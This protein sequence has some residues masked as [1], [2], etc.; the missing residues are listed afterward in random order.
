MILPSYWL[1]DVLLA[2]LKDIVIELLLEDALLKAL[3]KYISQ[4][5]SRKIEIL[6][7]WSRLITVGLK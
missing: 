3:L 5:G 2:R 7:S 6:K 1:G 4:N